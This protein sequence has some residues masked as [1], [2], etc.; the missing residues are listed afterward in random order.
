[1]SGRDRGGGRLRTLGLVAMLALTLAGMAAPRPALAA[2]D[3]APDTMAQSDEFSRQL[4]E[5]K[6]TM[7]ELNR[8]IEESA[9]SFDGTT[10]VEQAR[11]EL[12]GLRASVSG[13][14]GA[15]ADNGVV[16][17]LGAKALKRVRDKLRML[18]QDTRFTPQER[19]YL[20]ERWR[21]LNEGTERA[22]EDLGRARKRLA[23]LLG[24]LQANEDFI[25]ELVQLREG[26][27]ALQ[28]IRQL[29]TSIR[30]A[31]D[32]LARLIGGIKPPG[33]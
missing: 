4:G 25:D 16:S 10:D 11:H 12:E 27:K 9:K 22:T 7:A 33:V 5:L 2:A 8:K 23:E 18:E 1:M 17:Q 13:L 31:S 29:T 30:S 24:T 6:S 19:A 3:N 32:D 14:L 20:L 21:E 26:A 28:I 15:V